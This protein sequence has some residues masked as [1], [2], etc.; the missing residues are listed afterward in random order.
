VNP[1]DRLW[2]AIS[3]RDWVGVAAQLQPNVVVEL[4]ASGERLVGPEAYVLSHRL[5]P[6]EQ[7]VKVIHTVSG[8]QTVAVYAVL[9]TEAVTEHVMG[10]Y[11]LQETRIAHAVELWTADGATPPPGWRAPWVP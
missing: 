10:C 7:V 6:G 4:P 5:R 8:E 9:T 1:V 3:L 11:D 2:R